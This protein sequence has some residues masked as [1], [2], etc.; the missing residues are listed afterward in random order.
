MKRIYGM[1]AGIALQIQRTEPLPAGAQALPPYQAPPVE[2]SDCAPVPA[3][4]SN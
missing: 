2:C 1:A 4:D 3:L